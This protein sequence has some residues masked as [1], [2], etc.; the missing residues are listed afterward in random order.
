MHPIIRWG[1]DFIAAVQ[2]MGSP[3]LDALFRGASFLG[4]ELFFL[5]FLPF[6]LWC[7]DFTAGIRL[8]SYVFLSQ[9]VNIAA[10]DLFQLPRPAHYRPE[11]ARVKQGGYG[12]PSGHAQNTII[13]WGALAVW[14]GKA[15]VR[16]AAAVLVLMVGF[17]RVYL[18]V[19]F[20][21]DVLAGWGIGAMLLALFLAATPVVEERL[22]RMGL[23]PRIVLALALPIL[24]ALIHPAKDV[25][26][27][28]AAMTGLGL[29]AALFAHR[30]SFC[31]RGPWPRRIVRYLLGISVLAGL[32]LGLSAVFPRAG[33]A[34]YLPF[35]FLRYML[36]GLW[37]GLG[38]P[39]TFLKLRLAGKA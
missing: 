18:G 27:G 16:A 32:Y 8:G 33:S 1:L 26:G 5:L 23:I 14:S 38:A 9:F 13:L 34:L 25:V 30:R 2:R 24:L 39:W 19:H 10:K 20:P 37:A 4:S 35:R 22:T 7:V 6:I 28:L 29:G 11:L 36:L 17:S 12:L 15:W 3:A 31:A 21:T